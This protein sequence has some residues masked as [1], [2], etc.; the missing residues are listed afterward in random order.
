MNTAPDSYVQYFSIESKPYPFP[1]ALA[2]NYNSYYNNTYLLELSP[3][4]MVL[5]LLARLAD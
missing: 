1:I 3:W 2:P 4:V 5:V